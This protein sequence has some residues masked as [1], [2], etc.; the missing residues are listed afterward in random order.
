MIILKQD[1]NVCVRVAPSIAIF[2]F[3]LKMVFKLAESGDTHAKARY[4]Y[5]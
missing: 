1:E 4:E 2:Q 5:C 3:L